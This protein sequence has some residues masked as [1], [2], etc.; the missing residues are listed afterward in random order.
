MGTSRIMQDRMA[1][2]ATDNYFGRRAN[3]VGDVN[4]DGLDDVAATGQTPLFASTLA[5]TGRC[6]ESISVLGFSRRSPESKM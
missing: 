2:A 3:G 4:G 1:W 5:R 6:S